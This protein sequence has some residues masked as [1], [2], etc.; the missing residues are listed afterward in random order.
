MYF[1]VQS[2]S[3]SSNN[4]R[5]LN[6]TSWSNCLSYMEG[7]GETIQQINSIPDSTSVIVNSPSSTN[8]YNV[9]LKEVSTGEAF[10]YIIFQENYSDLQNWISQ[11]IGKVPTQILLSEKTYVNV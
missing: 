9:R 10:S 2:Q 3:I 6:A 4:Y 11:Q 1:L 8:C 5:I 7:T